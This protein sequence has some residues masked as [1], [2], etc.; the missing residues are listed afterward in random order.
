MS[1]L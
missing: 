1:Y